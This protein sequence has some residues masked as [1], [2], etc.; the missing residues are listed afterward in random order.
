[1]PREAWKV[2]TV[3]AAQYSRFGDP[4]VLTVGPVETVHAGPAE[5]RIAV[6]AT[7]VAPTDAKLRAGLLGTRRTLAWP[8]VPGVDAAG[9]VD[10]VGASVTGVAI[11]D[12]VFGA[13][14]VLRL[15]GANAEFAV[16]RFWEHKPAAMSW[17]A[18]GGAGTSVETATRALDALAIVPGMT[19]LVDG[20]AGGV[21]HVAVQLALARGA[22]VVG[23]GSPA[24][25]DHIAAFG[26]TPTTYG[27]GLPERVRS[28]APA[29]IDVALDVAGAGSLA[30]LVAVTGAPSRVLTIAD[31]TA[32]Q[33]GVRLSYSG[34]EGAVDG[35]HGLAQAAALAADGRF[36]LL[37]RDTLPLHRVAEAHVAVADGHG[38]GKVVLTVP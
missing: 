25:H 7:G 2:P 34:S 1:V 20:A 18:A 19:L 35:R 21:G 11:G 26:A 27:P 23:T 15:G 16:L 38:C 22:R 32:E 4:D 14:D 9:V 24:N 29:G 36:H 13:V 28:L 8:H 12:E 10:E 31:F 37:V 5:I 30:D 33:H 6:R 3:F 17:A